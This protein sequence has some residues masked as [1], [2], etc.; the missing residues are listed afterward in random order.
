[1]TPE[2]PGFIT[3]GRWIEDDTGAHAANDF[4]RAALVEEKALR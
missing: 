1:M 3:T 4:G 2:V